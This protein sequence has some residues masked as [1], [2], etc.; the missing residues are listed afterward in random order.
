MSKTGTQTI[1]EFVA[2]QFRFSVNHLKSSFGAV[3]NAET[4]TSTFLLNNPNNLSR[5]HG[6]PPVVYFNYKITR[7]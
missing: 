1:T 3:W 6:L 7:L 2:H 5:C 4:T